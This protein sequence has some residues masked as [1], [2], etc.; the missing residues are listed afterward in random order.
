MKEDVM[1]EIMQQMLTYLDNVQMRQLKLTMERVLIRYE[2]SEAS[3]EHEE[4]DSYD[5]LTKFISAKRVEGCSEKTIEYYQA[6]IETMIAEMNKNVRHI[7]KST[8]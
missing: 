1:M 8:I 4:D 6:T 7:V 5:I 2:I 3:G